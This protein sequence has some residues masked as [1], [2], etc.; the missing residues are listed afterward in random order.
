MNSLTE[1]TRV[2]FP[3]VST[4]TPISALGSA[5][6]NSKT[7]QDIIDEGGPLYCETG[8]DGGDMVCMMAIY[9][10]LT[11]IGTFPGVGNVTPIPVPVSDFV[12]GRP[13]RPVA[14]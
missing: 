8:I 5:T 3:G 11:L 2:Y 6:Y 12:G 10:K 4:T 13:A 7:V 9:G 1:L 14:K